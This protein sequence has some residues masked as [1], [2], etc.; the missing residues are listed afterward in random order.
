MKKLNYY[1]MSVCLGLLTLIFLEGILT[2]GNAFNFQSY[3]VFAWIAQT[4][5]VI[6]TITL[7]LHVAI[8]V[9]EDK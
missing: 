1:V 5:G 2:M 8:N 7:S 3:G 6:F 4:I 9:Q